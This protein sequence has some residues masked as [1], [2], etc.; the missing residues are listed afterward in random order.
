M[1]TLNDYWITEG[2][3]DFEYKKYKLLA[4]LKYVHNSFKNNLLYPEMSDLV[5]HY[6]NLLELKDSKELM[7]TK[8]PKELKKADIS[9]L[10]LIYQRLI[11]DDT[12]M[13]EIGQILDYSIPQVESTLE[14]GKAIHEFVEEQLSL[15]PIGLVPIYDKE[16]YLLLQK[17]NSRYIH[18][19]RYQV[20]FFQSSG[21]KYRA[22]N[23]QFIKDEWES[24]TNNIRQIKLNLI[25]TIKE[26][27][28]PATFFINSAYDFP[29]NETLLP[30]S[31]RL[32]LKQI[33]V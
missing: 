19:Y 25:K 11:T 32:L 17:G 13:E 28:N 16:G 22:I 15:E 23:F 4:Y 1:K 18:V 21:E 27:P 33:N 30:V 20:S 9:N 2:P 12:Y 6:R 24:I 29:L 31:K 5:Q 14:A 3:L 26:L 8:F 10:K 7:V